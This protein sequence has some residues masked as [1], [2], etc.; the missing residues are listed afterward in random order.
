MMTTSTTPPAMA[1]GRS[2]DREVMQNDRLAD[3]TSA[4]GMA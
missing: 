3:G 2:V 4:R 1:V